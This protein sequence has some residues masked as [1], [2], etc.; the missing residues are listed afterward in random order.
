MCPFLVLL[1]THSEMSGPKASSTCG[2]M[3][4]CPASASRTHTDCFSYRDL[5]CS[6]LSAT[7]PLGIDVT[8]GHGPSL[9]LVLLLSKGAVRNHYHNILFSSQHTTPTY[10]G[11][12]Q[13][14]IGTLGKAVWGSV[15]NCEDPF[16][17]TLFLPLVSYRK[18]AV[19]VA[20]STEFLLK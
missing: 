11:C 7:P 5:L 1:W 20:N 13:S 12:H 8:I 19:W 15:E 18:M 10:S 14:C 2:L 17:L 6:W 3:W 9:T 4:R 16:S